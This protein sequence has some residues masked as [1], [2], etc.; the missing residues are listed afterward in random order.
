[1]WCSRTISCVPG[2]YYINQSINI[3]PH[4]YILTSQHQWGHDLTVALYENVVELC[5]PTVVQLSELCWDVCRD[6]KR[7]GRGWVPQVDIDWLTDWQALCVFFF[8]GRCMCACVCAHTIRHTGIGS[9]VSSLSFHPNF[10]PPL[11]SLFSLLSGAGD[12]LTD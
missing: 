8:W 7:R 9:R 5:Q 11:P 10:N 3:T 12:I 4:N 6:E 2:L 1:M